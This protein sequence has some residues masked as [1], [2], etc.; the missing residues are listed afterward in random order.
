MP[1]SAAA[2]AIAQEHRVVDGVAARGDLE[3]RGVARRR[4]C[5]SACSRSTYA[6]AA[7]PRA[8]RVLR[9]EAE[10]GLE[11]RD[12]ELVDRHLQHASSGS[13]E[14][15]PTSETTSGLPSDSAL[16][17]EPGG[18]AHR[19]IAQVDQHVAGGH[20]RPHPLL[21]HVVEALDAV[22]E[23]EPLE[24]AVD[25]EPLSGGADEQE[26]RPGRA[27]G[28][29]RQRPRAAAGCACSCSGSRSS[30][31]AGRR[32]RRRP[33]RPRRAARPGCGMRQRRPPYPAARARS[34]T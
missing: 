28:A 25:V 17:T 15:Q 20:Q 10:R 30:R 27:C 13:S 3:R 24:P 16:I 31:S 5:G 23:T 2:S 8:S 1:T 33:A 7:A 26:P 22:G 4:R 14:N 29:A 11:R 9:G 12:L 18:L 32:R 34:A 21:G 19:R 6:R